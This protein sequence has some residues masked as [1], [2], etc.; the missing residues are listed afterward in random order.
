MVCISAMSM[1]GGTA[2][3]EEPPK[4][5]RAVRSIALDSLDGIEIKAV[6]EPG[7]EPVKV[8]ADI[9]AHNGR[10]ALHMLNNDSTM[11][12]SGPSGGE[13]LAIV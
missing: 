4:P 5:S 11:G 6:S 7:A 10:R 8:K 3:A 13:S 2:N 1:R 9:A 12:S